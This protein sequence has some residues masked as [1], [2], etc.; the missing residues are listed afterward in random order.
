MRPWGDGPAP[1][2]ETPK[3]GA[4]ILGLFGEDDGNP[5]PDDVAKIDAEL[6]RLNKPHEFHSYAGAGHAFMNLGR[7]S[8]REATA[9]DAWQKAVAWFDRYLK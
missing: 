7:P 5:N 6:T 9:E 4:P 2:D 8:Y 3:I 1:F